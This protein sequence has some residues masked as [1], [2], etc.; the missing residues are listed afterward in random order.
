M[1]TDLTPSKFW[2]QWLLVASIF[3]AIQGASWVFIGS[4]EPFGIYDGMVSRHFADSGTIPDS[5][6]PFYHFVIG[7]LGATDA[8]FFV[9]FAFIVKY[10]FAN[11]ERWSHHALVAGFLTW[12]ILD[13]GFS[14]YLGAWFNIACVNLP[15]LILIG[16]PL[17]ATRKGFYTGHSNVQPD[18]D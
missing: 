2:Q 6:R 14:I 17:F 10:P 5:A 8:A 13:C 4:F 7:L 1:S 3:L 18:K 16:L 9:L 12:F 15:C 11:G